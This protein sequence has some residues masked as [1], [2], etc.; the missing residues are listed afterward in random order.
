M[1]MDCA[2]RER[3]I[4]AH[5]TLARLVGSTSWSTTTMYFEK[6]AAPVHWAASAI[7]WAAWPAYLCSMDTTFMPI[8]VASGGHQTPLT[9]TTP[10]A[11]RLFHNAADLRMAIMNSLLAGQSSIRLR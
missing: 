11:S 10:R 2:G 3:V 8:D 5:T 4:I 6:Y 7:T 9:P 1:S